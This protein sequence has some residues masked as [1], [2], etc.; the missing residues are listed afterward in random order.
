[1]FISFQHLTTAQYVFFSYRFYPRTMVVRRKQAKLFKTNKKNKVTTI[2]MRNLDILHY[3]NFNVFVLNNLDCFQ[4][5]QCVFKEINIKFEK[6]IS[7]SFSSYLKLIFP[8]YKTKQ[9]KNMSY[10]NNSVRNIR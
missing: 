5:F 8:F 9:D 7:F 4:H 1:M 6:R 10:Q 2:N 3:T